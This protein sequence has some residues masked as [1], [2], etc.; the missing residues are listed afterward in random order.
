VSISLSNEVKVGLLTLL[1]GVILYVGFNFLKGIE[2]FSPSKSYF[3]YYDNLGGLQV[4]NPVLVNGMNVGRV[5]KID[6]IQNGQKIRMLVKMEI[7][8]QLQL[9]DSTYA[10]L[11]DASVLG[12]K[13]I[14]LDIRKGNLL[15]GN[16]TLSSFAQAGLTDQ[17]S[18]KI[19]PLAD[20][21]DTLIQRLNRMLLTYQD[22]SDSIRIIMGHSIRITRTTAGLLEENRKNMT[23]MLTNLNTLS[24]SLVETEKQFKPLISKFNAVADSVQAM[25]LASIGKEMN[26][27]LIELHKSL[28]AINEAQGTIGKLL[29]DSTM[30]VNSNKAVVD[31]DKLFIDLKENPK[32]YVHFSMFG[33]KEKTEK[34]EKKK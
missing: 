20:G 11:N 1:S 29:K 2:L 21:A 34:K 22:M 33:K 10:I 32:R 3:V 31:L 5:S 13:N 15:K 7:D 6:I 19:S 30:Y 28:A 24:T 9:T 17:L 8:D 12:G 23:T 26:S 4:S 25:P 16:D 14:V 27:S 18:S